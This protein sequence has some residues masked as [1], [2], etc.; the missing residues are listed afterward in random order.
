MKKFCIIFFT[1]FIISV[2]ALQVMGCTPQTAPT[3][4]EYFRMHIRADSNEK[5]A[6]AVKYLVRDSVVE[7]LTPFIAEYHTQAEAVVGVEER[8]TQ[9]ESTANAVLQENGFAYGAKAKICIEQFPTR[10][11]EQYTLPAGEYTALI[12]ELGKAEGDNWWCVVY[13]PL[14]FTATQ[15]NVQYKSKILEIIKA[16]RENNKDVNCKQACVNSR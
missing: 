12:I 3:Q 16:W 6:Q 4:T 7:Y 10:V 8:L 15:G 13:P 5:E 1:F 9:I 14:C 11:Y 2:T